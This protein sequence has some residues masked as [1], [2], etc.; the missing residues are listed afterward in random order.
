MEKKDL[1][2]EGA[3]I[4]PLKIAALYPQR[5][6]EMIARAL[7]DLLVSLPAIGTALIW[8][9][10]DRNVPWK[11]YYAGVRPE[12]IRSWLAARLDYSLDATLGVLQRDLSK[13]SD[14]PFPRLICLQPAP[15]FPAGLW[16]IWPTLSPLPREALDYQEKVRLIL[17]ALI[18]VE[19]LEGHYFS[20]ISPLSDQE[21]IKGL[22]QGD[23]HASSTLLSLTRLIGNADLTFWGRAYQDVVECTDHM[24]TKQSGF[25]F[26]IPRGQGVGGRVAASGTPIMIVEDYRN[27]PY[28]HPN[29]S[30]IVDR[31]QIRSGIILPVRTRQGQEKSGPVT[32]ILYVT[33]RAVKPFSLAEQLLVQRLTH[34]LEPLPPPT[35]PPSFRSPGL[36]KV[37]DEKATWHKL[38]LHA[39]RIES[40]ETWIG[41][42]IQGTIIV[43][44]SEGRPYTS[45][46]AEQLEHLRASFDRSMDGVQ[47]ISLDAPDVSLPGQVYLRSGVPLPP[48]SWPNFFTDLVVAC[49]LI[50]GRMQQARNHLA[51]QREQWLHA[52]LQEKSLPYIRQDGHQLGLPIGEGHLWVIAWPSQRLLTRSA[53]RSRMLAENIVLDQ[54][55][56]PLLF[57]GDDIGVIL[58]DSYAEVL[59]SRLH[60]ALLTLFAPYPLWIVYGAHYHSLHDLKMVLTYCITLAQKARREAHSENLLDIQTLGLESLLANPRVTEDLRHFATE[61]L[62]PLLEYDKSKGT[63]LTITFVLAQTLGSAQTVSD[64]LGVHV[65]TI[66]YRLH[67]AE[68]ILGIE[69]AS[70]KERISW[71]VASFIWA[72]FHPLELTVP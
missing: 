22:A 48:T 56:S 34:L 55:E 27:S 5:R 65:N 6:G 7:Q 1:I 57:L 17:E 59:P 10:Q 43:T 72:S 37:P 38:I 70:P 31:E 67:K 33:R 39:N 35:R 44:D 32:G 51:Y 25:G 61:L 69:E 2:P 68:D 45:A 41:Q 4:H 63:D 21:L 36:P 12:S 53:A 3:A 24:G 29:V 20:S 50:I 18:E 11:V 30:A 52:V 66:R 14:L 16:I 15:M 49:N 58:L 47:V 60:D 62:T 26:A 8:P 42:F 23:P 28:R 71:G 40:L 19:S 9:G 64:V 46:R 13:L 54:L